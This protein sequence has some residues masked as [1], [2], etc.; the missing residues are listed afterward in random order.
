MKTM[1]KLMSLMLVFT[2]SIFV[3]ATAANAAELT[4]DTEYGEMT[5]SE[6]DYDNYLMWQQDDGQYVV[7]YNGE[8]TC[9]AITASEAT[10]SFPGTAKVYASTNDYAAEVG[11]DKTG[12]VKYTALEHYATNKAFTYTDGVNTITLNEQEYTPIGQAA[13][14]AGTT[15]VSVDIEATVVNISVPLSVSAV[16][17]V[18][19]ADALVFGDIVIQNNTKAPVRISLAKFASTDLPFTN[20]IAPADLPNELDWENLNAA[21]SA[22]YFSLGIKPIDTVNTPWKSMV[23]DYVWAVPG[24]VKT[25]LGVIEAE[26]SSNL[27][28]DARFG[29]IQTQENSFTFSAT[30]VA[31]LE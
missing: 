9:S 7:F 10:L 18:N 3:P 29:R 11:A 22:K 12:V 19:E 31:E 4:F 27:G 24:F 23:G 28:I 20:L 8:I 14:F 30:F 5:V 25:E 17:N 2:I 15:E 26:S 13:Q 21:N 16:I 6:G 1:K